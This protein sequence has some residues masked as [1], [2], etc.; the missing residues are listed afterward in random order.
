M[1]DTN[2]HSTAKTKESQWMA[3]EICLETVVLVLGALL[4]GACC[5]VPCCLL[6]VAWC[7]VLGAGAA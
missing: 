6:L 4:L 2:P 7:L 5:S 3:L 1:H